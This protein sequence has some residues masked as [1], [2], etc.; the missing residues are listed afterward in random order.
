M[1]FSQPHYRAADQK[2]EPYRNAWASLVQNLK[3][4]EKASHAEIE[5]SSNP[6]DSLQ[7][8][9]FPK[10]WIVPTWAYVEAPV[11]APHMA[12]LLAQIHI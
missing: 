8:S 11:L 12:V 1:D 10:V 4:H 2:I 7:G 5:S 6:V 3:V 9:L